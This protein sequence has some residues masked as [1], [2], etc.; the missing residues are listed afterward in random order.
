MV[1]T[2]DKKGRKEYCDR[3][4][5]IEGQKALKNRLDNLIAA[6]DAGV[7]YPIKYKMAG[8]P[9]IFLKNKERHLGMIEDLVEI[10]GLGTIKEEKQDGD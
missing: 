7:K 6:H 8:F 2:N 10:L 4:F 1:N 9:S 3:Y 5:T